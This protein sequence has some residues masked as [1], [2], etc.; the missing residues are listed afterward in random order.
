MTGLLLQ[1]TPQGRAV[2]M[3]G[4][5]DR[6]FPMNRVPS[7]RI[8]RAEILHFKA[9][10]SDRFFRGQMDDSAG[11]LPGGPAGSS[12]NHFDLL[13]PAVCGPGLEFRR[14]ELVS[15]PAQAVLPGK[16][17]SGRRGQGA[18]HL[19]LFS[20]S[21]YGYA[22]AAADNRKIVRQIRVTQKIQHDIRF[23]F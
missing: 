19:G 20:G 4:K 23:D 13:E 2:N 7:G 21:H 22:A 8:G 15:V 12:A 11:S 10:A 5:V 1:G 6:A 14:S 3:A 16:S 9:D 17:A 18:C